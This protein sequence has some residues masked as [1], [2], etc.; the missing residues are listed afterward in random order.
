MAA[1]APQENMTRS[2]EQETIQR[3]VRNHES[4][5]SECLNLIASENALSPTVKRYLAC[6]LVQRYGD[7][8]GRDYTARKYQG[9]RWVE[10]IEELVTDMAAEL[11]GAR[12]AETRPISG[13]VA[14]S[15]V[16]MALTRPGDVILE[17]SRDIGS[18]RMAYKLGQ[19][20]AM[21]LDVRFLPVDPL[22][23]N[24]DLEQTLDMIEATRPRMVILG[25][26]NFLF[27]HPVAELAAALQDYPDTILVY[28]AS[29]VFGL[30]A[31]GCFQ[32]P[33]REGARVVFGSTHKTLPGPQ[34]GLILTDD[35]D[36]M[37]AMAH[38]IYPALVTNHHL[39]R[40]PALGMALLELKLWGRD[41]A[42]QIVANAQR[43]GAEIQARGVNVVSRAADGCFT[44][45]HTLLVKVSPFGTA[46]QVAS[47]LE[48]ANIIVTAAHLPEAL[49]REG[50]RLG[51]QEITRLGAT[52]EHMA[53][54]A[55]WIAAVI[56]GAQSPDKARPHVRELARHL[57]HP[58]F[59]WA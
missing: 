43:L 10:Q 38:A 51:V 48:E 35:A 14:G 57:R 15:A 41:Y 59:T 56:S 5:R 26:S 20:P 54:I 29:H 34:G 49:G 6:D 19:T 44:Q 13:H 47:R 39:F 32:D 30:I 45:S 7:Y 1:H 22:A 16:I 50:V 2:D 24:L 36:L 25:S 53:P 28:D 23:F 46:T 11:F 33:I 52:P 17:V 58:H 9:T 12:L 4:W 8:E 37:D 31:G 18:H 40:L 55:E 21:P 3:L 27:P 42:N